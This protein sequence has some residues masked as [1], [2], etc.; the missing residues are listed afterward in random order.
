VDPD[1]IMETPSNGGRRALA[2][3]FMEMAAQK[4][5]WYNL[6][7]PSVSDEINKEI[8]AMFPLLS[9]ILHLD[10]KTM[11]KVL[12]K[13]GLCKEYGTISTPNQLQFSLFIAE[14]K[15]DI[16][17][18]EFQINNKRLYLLRIGSFDYSERPVRK[19]IDYK[20]KTFFI[21]I[22]ASLG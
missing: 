2:D 17:F 6:R 9:S 16:E 14:Y 3:L 22:S 15:L 13:C 8:N 10:V 4:G 18:T 7:K 20:T 5:H 21:Q 11:D 19:P 12:K 1:F